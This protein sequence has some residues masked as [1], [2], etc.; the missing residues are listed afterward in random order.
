M[1][2][3]DWFYRKL[4]RLPTDLVWEKFGFRPF[5]VNDIVAKFDSTDPDVLEE[6]RIIILTES[7]YLS[8]ILT[9]IQT[10]DVFYDIGAHVGVH[11]SFAARKISGGKVLAFEPV[12][13]NV[14]FLKK[15]LDLNPGDTHIFSIAIADKYGSSSFAQ[16]KNNRE[17]GGPLGAIVP[18]NGDYS[19]DTAPMDD[20]V[21][22]KNLP[23]PNVIKVDVEGAEPLVLKGMENTL[24]S[25]SCRMLFLEVHL[26]TPHI[27]RPSID[28]FDSSV[29]DIMSYLRNIGFTVEVVNARSW[30][31]HLKAQKDR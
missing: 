21:V 25:S 5:S 14:Q 24:T 16:P 18:T 17:H 26:P 7:D 3:T 12:P 10:D 2:Y 4:M 15:N 11:A 8:E 27:D 29:I 6:I 1:I 13:T 20:L 23:K 28:H 22:D 19:V 9:H 30:V 31:L